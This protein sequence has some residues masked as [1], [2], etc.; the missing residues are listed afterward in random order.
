MTLNG[1]SRDSLHVP[2]AADL[3]F[4][5]RLPRRSM[6][7]ADCAATGDRGTTIRF[8]ASVSGAGPSSRTF[9]DVDADTGRWKRLTLPLPPGLQRITLSTRLLSGPPAR[10]A[11]W[12]EPVI[13]WPKSAAELRRS[14]FF[15][16]RAYGLR[17][18]FRRLRDSVAPAGD[19]VYA[20]W[21]AAKTRGHAELAQLRSNVA[22]M[23]CRPHVALCLNHEGAADAVV[24][25]VRSLGR[26]VYPNW[27]LW[28]S[29]SADS[30]L[31]DGVLSP[32]HRRVLPED[33]VGAAA[34]NRILDS[35]SADFFATLEPGDEL[36]PDALF[37][38]ANRLNA[39]PELDVLYSDEDELTPSGTHRSPKFKPG[40]SPE[41]LLARMYLG[42]LTVIRLPTASRAGG[43]R[44]SFEG[45]LDYD[46]ALRL[47]TH[48]RVGHIARVLYHR[49]SDNVDVASSAHPAAARAIDAHCR[50]Q[51]REVEVSAGAA[52]GVWRAR[53]R[54]T[55][56]AR[57]TIVIPTDAQ[58]SPDGD[59]EPLLLHC[60]RGIQER[61]SYADYDVLI[62]DNG[63]LPDGARELLDG[64]PHRR[65]SY[66]YQGPFNFSDKINFA[67]SHVE[68]PYVLLLNDDVEPINPD[69]LSA[70]VEYAQQEP[71]G[72]V[73]AKLFYP[74]GR[75]Q[76]AGVAVGVSGIAAHLLHQHPGGTQGCGGLAIAVRNC[77]AVTGACLL[78]RRRV[79]AEAGGFN[80]R[81]AVDFND[82]DFCLKVRRAG[83]RIVFTPYARLYHHESASFGVRSQR[84][85]E[86][87]EMRRTWGGILDNDPYY[88]PNLSRDFP[89]CRVRT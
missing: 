1:Q 53:Y 56:G 27:E 76:H 28:L 6:L 89:D 46:L 18:T 23:A 51:G 63:R 7:L 82:V 30:S 26:Q 47:S 35:S 9:I 17:G 75:L 20:G 86:V 44:S 19:D 38:V 8:E 3:A 87:E 66:S 68:A 42:R 70:M 37:E 21:F 2:V 71:I 48:A 69:W 74:D 50:A 10:T 80:T 88:N 39:E 61:T 73:G 54:L 49:S 12:G 25:T 60:L 16:L 57:V 11:L 29:R 13:T 65:V 45:A 33:D 59:G 81:L 34:R 84:E 5:L 32:A 14:A 78:T 36:A 31:P 64:V 24:R 72:A 4:H 85:S 77:S 52:A 83:Y 62:V 79:Y 67:V 22:G 43:Y 41:H 40:W 58:A 15:V 55:P